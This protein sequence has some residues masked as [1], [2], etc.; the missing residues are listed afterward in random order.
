MKNMFSQ[1]KNAI[2]KK[3]FPRFLLEGILIVFVAGFSIGML[4]FVLRLTPLAFFS[5]FS[6]I[7][8]YVFLM[9]RLRNSFTAYFKIYSIL[10]VIFVA[11]GYYIMRVSS[12]I[13]VFTYQK[14]TLE[15][16]IF[17]PFKLFQFFYNWNGVDVIISNVLDILFFLI[18]AFFTYRNLKPRM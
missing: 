4:D 7:F 2:F 8:F 12:L 17:N 16:W 14:Q 11:L 1:F 6:F 13:A 18:I 10:A 5:L 9:R 15:P 3:E